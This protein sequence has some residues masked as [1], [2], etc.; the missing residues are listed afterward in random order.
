MKRRTFKRIPL[1]IQIKFFSGKTEYSG[2][3]MNFS[4]KGMFISTE[5]NFPLNAY[6]EIFIP[7]KDD[8]LKVFA[9]VRNL[10]K[11]DDFYNGIGV[12]LIDP[13]QNYKEFIDSL[14]SDL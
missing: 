11:L 7:V 1:K 9:E 12:Q 4:E 6:L 10:K 2:T 3:M 13:P 8:V 14:K 5:V